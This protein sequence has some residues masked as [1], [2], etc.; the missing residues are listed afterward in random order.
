MKNLDTLID[1][2]LKSLGITRTR[3]AKGP[4][5]IGK[6]AN[7]E[8][9]VVTEPTET[10]VE[11]AQPKYEIVALYGFSANYPNN[12][13]LEFNPKSRREKGDLVFH[14]ADGFK[15]FLSWG[16]LADARKRYATAAEQASDSIKRSL[17]SSR[18]K[19]DGSPETRSMKIMNHDAAFTHVRMFVD[20]GGFLFGSKRVIQEAYSIHLHCGESKRFYVIYAFGRPD[21]SEELGKTIEPIVSSLKCH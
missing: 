4:R 19:L 9:L 1:R 15:I 20:R 2:L 17:N 5:R 13:R 18:A 3:V 16:N 21:I 6:E 14:T 8:E 11:A 12:A 7:S 10:E